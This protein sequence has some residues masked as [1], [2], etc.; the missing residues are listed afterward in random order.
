MKSGN[1]EFRNDRNQRQIQRT[2]QSDARQNVAHVLGSAFARPDARNESAVLPHVV[3]NFIRI[4]N[5]RRIE[6]AEENDA[7]DVQQVVQ[8]L[9]DLD[10]HR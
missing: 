9:A 6:I 8:R 5:D 7:D 4:E 3:C 1:H 2:D 10:A